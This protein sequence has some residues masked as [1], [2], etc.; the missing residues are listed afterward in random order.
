MSLSLSRS[1]TFSLLTISLD[2]SS[3]H[4]PPQ[5]TLHAPRTA[6]SFTHSLT[7]SLSLFLFPSVFVP[8]LD[9]VNTRATR[10]TLHA[11]TPAMCAHQ[12]ANHDHQLTIYL[13]H[14]LASRHP[15][16]LFLS[17]SLRNGQVTHSLD[18]LFN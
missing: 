12:L 7:L 8:H 4:T 17:L 5:S 14:T 10:S 11:H 1:L 16:T 13:T 6:L 3:V 18:V 9:C 15:P 2:L